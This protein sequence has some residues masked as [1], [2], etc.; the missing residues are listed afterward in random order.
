MSSSRNR[1]D[2]ADALGFSDR[3]T[4]IGSTVSLTDLSLTSRAH[5]PI[6]FDFFPFNPS[7]P[8]RELLKPMQTYFVPDTGWTCVGYTI[9]WNANLPRLFGAIK[10]IFCSV[11]KPGIY[12]DLPYNAHHR[13][14][15]VFYQ[16]KCN[17]GVQNKK[18]IRIRSL[19]QQNVSTS[20]GRLKWC[21]VYS[22][23]LPSS[24]SDG[25]GWLTFAFNPFLPDYIAATRSSLSMRSIIDFFRLEGLRVLEGF[26]N[27]S[28]REIG[29]SVPSAFLNVGFRATDWSS[30]D[31]DGVANNFEPVLR[32]ELVDNSLFSDLICHPVILVLATYWGSVSF[33]ERLHIC[34]TYHWRLGLRAGKANS[35]EF[36]LTSFSPPPYDTHSCD[37]QRS[38]SERLKEYPACKCSTSVVLSSYERRRYGHISGKTAASPTYAVSGCSRKSFA[39]T[40]L[41]LRSVLGVFSRQWLAQFHSRTLK[42]DW[43][44]L[45]LVRF[46]L[47]A[48]EW[49]ARR[50][51]H[52]NRQCALPINSALPIVWVRFPFYTDIALAKEAVEFLLNDHYVSE[53]SRLLGYAVFVRLNQFSPESIVTIR[54]CRGVLRQHRL[55][56]YRYFPLDLYGSVFGRLGFQD[57]ESIPAAFFHFQ[58]F[59]WRLLLGECSALRCEAAFAAVPALTHQC[60]TSLAKLDLLT[61][62]SFDGWLL[63]HH[64]GLDIQYSTLS[65]RISL[66][67]RT[68]TDHHMHQGRILRVA[69]LSSCLPMGLI[70]KR[71]IAYIS[72]CY[73]SCK[74]IFQHHHNPELKKFELHSS[75][76]FLLFYCT[77]DFFRLVILGQFHGKLPFVS[78]L[79][80]RWYGLTPMIVD[81]RLN[82]GLSSNLNLDVKIGLF[83]LTLRST[84][85]TTL[86]K[87]RGNVSITM[88]NRRR[89]RKAYMKVE[90]RRGN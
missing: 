61:S 40:L 24:A 16:T 82:A 67:R 30:G 79:S 88:P 11:L 8:S 77:L 41:V 84:P 63:Q 57:L 75:V 12:A 80:A 48:F 87:G 85:M 2:F 71:T 70:I 73:C 32:R 36:L 62:I 31:T 49:L 10:S 68:P 59:S 3:G 33:A 47:P 26:Q 1:L 74:A 65:A 37:V 22:V 25:V 15:L 35:F 21:L 86:Q 4:M 72:A 50:I 6:L 14:R 28:R 81:G 54:F 17:P 76:W 39:L 52:W 55:P 7:T 66:S 13:Y 23:T 18:L 60:G 38:T 5:S 29:S 56:D 90:K 51:K 64:M 9:S 78:S 44:F 45:A 34:E 53:L 69:Q 58:A 46:V 19:P 89:K 20:Q 83:Q 27:S 43:Y 42:K